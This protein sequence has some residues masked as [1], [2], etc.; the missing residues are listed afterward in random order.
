MTIPG[1]SN[2]DIIDVIQK[3]AKNH[4]NKRFGCYTE[5]D[6]EQE[7]WVIV[8][9]RISDFD[10]KKCKVTDPKSALERWLNTVVSRRLVNFHRDNYLV[11][12]RTLKSDKGDGE[13]Q[14]RHSL[15]HPTALSDVGDKLL[16]VF[17]S[18]SVLENECWELVVKN[19]NPD[20][21]DILESILSGEVV[22]GY[23]R[24]K[25]YARVKEILNK[26]CLDN[27]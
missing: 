22:N 23:Y 16:T 13:V 15:M 18:E 2:Q 3:V 24:N 4:R 19:L 7:V 1:L 26:Q 11:P 12:Q 6:I 20:L 9:N 14:K 25:L 21:S 8:Q 17:S 10:L 5:E 27:D